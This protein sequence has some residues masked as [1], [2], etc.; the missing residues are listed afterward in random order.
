M[1]ERVPKIEQAERPTFD[2]RA[3]SDR[4]QEGR[5]EPIARPPAQAFDKAS[6][7]SIVSLAEFVRGKL[8]DTVNALAEFT[9]GHESR[10]T[11]H[12]VRL[13]RAEAEIAELK[14]AR[15]PFGA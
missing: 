3:Y 6:K 14:A 12:G 15:P 1:A 9:A 4:L 13:N 5:V 2:A 10:L 8:T 7:S 11:A